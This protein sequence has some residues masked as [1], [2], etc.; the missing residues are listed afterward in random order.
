MYGR[1]LLKLSGEA[2]GKPDDTFDFDTLE[3]VCGVIKRVVDAGVQTALVVGGGNIWRGRAG[4]AMDRT[5][6]DQ[7]GML[8]TVIN[9]LAIADTLERLGVAADVQS[10]LRTDAAEP[11]NRSRAVKSL[12]DGRVVIFAGGLGNPFFTTD[13]AAILRGAEINADAVLLAKNIDGVY[14]ADPKKDAGAVKYDTITYERALDEKLGVTDLTAS[15][16]GLT[17]RVPLYVFE[18]KDPENIYR[19]AMQEK[20]G[21]LVT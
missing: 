11:F 7:M 19:A 15:A 17:N 18:L 2:L 16:L 14:S 5:R 21:T 6:A 3:R 10:A 8:A 4:A 12:E 13:T 1:I 20:I 9:A